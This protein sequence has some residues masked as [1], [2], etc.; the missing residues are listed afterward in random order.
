M[1]PFAGE[2]MCAGFRDAVALSWRLNAIMERKLDDVVLDSYVSERIHHAKHYI[3][4][5]QQLGSI[6][7]IT[8]TEEAEQRDASMKAELAARNH[9]P[10]TGDLVHL[11]SG[12]W[13]ED[14]A[15]AGELSTQGFVE[16]DGKRDRFDQH[17][18]QGWMVVGLDADPR[19]ALS[20]QQ[21][22]LLEFLSGKTIKIGTT[23]SDCDAMDIDG[24]YKKWLS[25]IDASYFILR[26][27]FYL[28]AT[29][30]TAQEVSDRLDQVFAKL[31]LNAVSQVS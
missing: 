29:A 25:S 26:P 17:M 15:G 28:A 1:P 22:D 14:S 9:E 10:I 21:L 18:G 3:D 8:D 4:F 13:C 31:H 24:T 6:I 7:C 20:Q 12:V 2:G 5:S 23:E 27:D 11:G 19:D 30:G 16:V